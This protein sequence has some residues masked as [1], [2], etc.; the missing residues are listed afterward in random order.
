MG[1]AI[2]TLDRAIGSGISM[3]GMLVDVLQVLLG[4]SIIAL[5]GWG[6]LRSEDGSEY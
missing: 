6:L 2:A 4:V 3:L 5:A 1:L